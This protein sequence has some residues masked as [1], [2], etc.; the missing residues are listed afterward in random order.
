MGAM[1]SRPSPP[2]LA[3]RPAQKSGP[4]SGSALSCSA[5]S[6][7]GQVLLNETRT[8]M[9][10]NLDE[11]RVADTAEAMDLPRLDDEN[12]AS[13]GFEFLS[14]D[15]PEAPTFPDELDFIVRMTMGPGTTPGER[16]EEEGGDIDVA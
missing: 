3:F 11:G 4:Q 6:A 1:A 9:D 2:R 16:A 12:V 5:V 8:E 7:L 13:A 14:V 10:I 15:G